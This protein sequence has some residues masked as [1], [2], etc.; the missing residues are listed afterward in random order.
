[1]GFVFLGAVVVEICFVEV[2][3]VLDHHVLVV[4][5]GCMVVQNLMSGLFIEWC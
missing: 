1:M 3:H 5:V 2:G 4:C